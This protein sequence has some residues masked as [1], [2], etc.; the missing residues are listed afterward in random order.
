MVKI[1]LGCT[2]SVASIKVPV[3][4]EELREF[5]DNV[6]ISII[7]TGNSLHFFDVKE[8]PENVIIYKDEDEWTTWKKRGDPIMHIDLGKWADLFL[9]APLDANTLAKMANGLCDNLLTSAVRAW[10]LSK[11]LI[12]CPAMNTKMYDHPLTGMQINTLLSWGYKVVPVVEKTLV[13][14]DRGLGAMAEVKTIVEFV[15][16]VCSV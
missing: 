9:I 6:E 3:L 1:L 12:F 4:V 13:C 7:V 15:M 2:G 10:E 16:R 8:I 5:I 11:P 14:G